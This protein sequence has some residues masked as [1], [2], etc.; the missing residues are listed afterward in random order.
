[1]KSD[2][3]PNP[4]LSDVAGGNRIRIC[5]ACSRRIRIRNDVACRI[6]LRKKIVSDPQLWFQAAGGAAPGTHP[7]RQEGRHRGRVQRLLLHAGVPG[8]RR[9]VLQSEASALPCQPGIRLQGE[10]KNKEMS[11]EI[12]D[13]KNLQ[14]NRVLGEV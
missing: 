14:T 8:H 1:M 6:R 4:D 7:A 5:V 10:K 2:P 12:N 3:D 11:T 13:I 9:D